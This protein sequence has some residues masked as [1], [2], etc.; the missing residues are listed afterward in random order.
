MHYS[1]HYSSRGNAMLTVKQLDNLK[2]KGSPYREWDSD[3]SGFGVQVSKA[4]AV[5]FFQHY[6]FEGKRRFLNLEP[7][8]V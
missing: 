7:P 3:R 5:S 2:P 1:V 8:R 4:G 6:T